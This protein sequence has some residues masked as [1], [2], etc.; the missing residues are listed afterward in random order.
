MRSRP[1]TAIQGIEEI[2][3]KNLLENLDSDSISEFPRESHVES[4]VNEFFYSYLIK[5][6]LHFLIK[7]HENIDSPKNKLNVPKTKPPSVL[8]VGKKEREKSID[9]VD[10]IAKPA[11]SIKNEDISKIKNSKL[12]SKKRKYCSRC[13]DD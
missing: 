7:K 12:K 6:K 4:E 3:E 1:T 11:S 8:G 2:D 10:N 13:V 9:G 5:S